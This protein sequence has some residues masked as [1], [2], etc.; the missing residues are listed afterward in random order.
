MAEKIGVYFDESSLGGFLDL[1][2]IAESVKNK[3]GGLCA[4][5]EAHPRLASADGKARIQA[6]LD[7]GTIDAVCVCGPT[8]RVDWEF[9]DFGENVLVDRVNLREQCVLS[10]QDPDGREL[11][12]GQT[13]ETLH[14]IALDY[15]NMGVVKLQKA[16]V[17]EAE[18]VESTKTIMVLGG[19]WTGLTAALDAAAA[20]H[21]VVLVEKEAVLG[22]AAAK[23]YKTIPLSYPYEK[24]HPTGVEDKISAVQGNDRIT[25]LTSS[26]L[27]SL[28]GMPGQF[29]AVV[30]VTKEE[31]IIPAG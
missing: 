16:T 5:I 22:G 28:S 4:V 1:E 10:Y 23:M 2:K 12:L 15:V 6:A 7:A 3:W 11:V 27:T 14:A 29:E 8:P 19:G 26:E 13:P 25:V 21:D 31:Q 18:I 30:S 20:G 9:F 17:P 24:A